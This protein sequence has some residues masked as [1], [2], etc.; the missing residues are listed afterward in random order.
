MIKAIFFD[1]DGVLLDSLEANL[2]F[3][4]DLMVKTNYRPPTREEFSSI[5]HLSMMD[6]I[7]AL[8]KSNS[9]E[10]IKRI[11]EIGRGREVGYDLDLLKTPEGAEEVLETLNERYRLG[12]I[13]SRIKESVYESPK[14]AKFEKYFKVAV[15][16]QDTTNHKPHPE[17]LLFASQKLNVKPEECIYIGDAENDAEAARAAGMKVIIYSKD[18]FSQADAHTDSFI[19]LPKLILALDKTNTDNVVWVDENDNELGIVAREKAHREGLIHRIAVI[20]L[21]KK[22]G[23]ILIQERMSG[24]LDHSSAGHVDIG[25]DYL[26]AAKRE[27]KEELG[28]DCELVEIGKTIS[29]EVEPET[30]Q[31]R[32][33]HIFKIFEC[34]AEPG[35]LA[36]NEVRS[37]FWANPK[38]IFEEMKDDIGN[39]KFCGGFK[40]SL[41]FF[42][43]KKKLL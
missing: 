34:K 8:T 37:V 30:S 40:A 16:Y 22:S 25:E 18:N 42:L 39:K 15:S 31:N 11:W 13:T 5:F 41:K 28:V 10:E 21:T 2:K 27:L 26:Q 23:E 7:K 9:E 24:R 1:I 36:K 17:P 12:I 43:E 35:R 38:T 29:D 33:R 32:I 14:L 4:Q 3:F 6:A 19:D 20:Y